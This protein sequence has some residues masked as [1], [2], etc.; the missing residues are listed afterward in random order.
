[1]KKIIT[2]DYKPMIE[3]ICNRFGY[4]YSIIISKKRW[5]E[6]IKRRC[7]I[8]HVLYQYENILPFYISGLV[9][10][11]HSTILRS[12]NYHEINLEPEYLKIR[13]LAI[14]YYFEFKLN[15]LQGIGELINEKNFYYHYRN[16]SLLRQQIS[17]KRK[18]NYKVAL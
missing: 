8:I 9:E 7:A 16:D 3:Y 12:I 4:E 11:D 10:Q 5:H 18:K 14:K 2:Q 17:V 15:E 6:I 1:M 13:S